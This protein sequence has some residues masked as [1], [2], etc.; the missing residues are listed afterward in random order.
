MKGFLVVAACIVAVMVAIKDG[1]ILRKAGLTGGCISIATPR[2]ETGAWHKCTAGRLQGAPDL[3][4]QGCTAVSQF[5]KTE[6]WRCPAPI[7]SAQGT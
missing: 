5:G 7:D 1:R 4:R 6:F 2:G 3:H